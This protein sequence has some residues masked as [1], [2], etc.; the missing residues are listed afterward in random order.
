MKKTILAGLAALSLGIGGAAAQQ[1]NVVYVLD[2]SN[3][4]WGQIDG[5]AKIETAK[6]VLSELVK[7]AA[8]SARLG[9]VAYGHRDADSCTDIEVLAALGSDGDTLAAAIEGVTPKGKTPISASLEVASEVFQNAETSNNIVLISDGIET[10]EADPCATAGALKEKG[11]ST[12]IHVVG[13]DVNEDERRA[14]ECI[15]DAGG[16]NYYQAANADD[17]KVAMTEVQQEAA[18]PKPE[19]KTV[20]LDEFDGSELAAH[21]VIGTPDPDSFLVENGNLLMLNTGVGGVNVPE[22]PNLFR[23]D[24]ELPDGDWDI[25]MTFTG[26]LKTSR[27]RVEVALWKDAENYMVAR[28]WSE[29]K[30]CGCSNIAVTIEKLSGGE[31]TRF[32]TPLRGNIGCGGPGEGTID[33][34]TANLEETPAT[35]VLSKRGRSYHAQ[36]R[37]EGETNEAGEQIVYETDPLTSLRSP[38]DLVFTAGKFADAGGEILVFIDKIEILA[39]EDAE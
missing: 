13:F 17:F 23:F 28:F 20:F 27:D 6:S 39:V 8:G 14:L 10:C 29:R 25:E 4:M 34:I 7:G 35:L 33:E 26:E 1:P 38:G 15:A 36:F 31:A 18:A 24:Q 2:G 5:T 30:C 11:V 3:S 19:P 32:N 16:G 12:R 37:I 22:T 21:W 9:L